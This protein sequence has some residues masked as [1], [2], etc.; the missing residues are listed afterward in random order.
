MRSLSDRHNRLTAVT[1]I[2][3]RVG[4]VGEMWVM[5]DQL[6]MKPISMIHEMECDFRLSSTC[7]VVKTLSVLKHRALR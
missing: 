6:R 5:R 3:L 4:N 7:G 2:E 1:R